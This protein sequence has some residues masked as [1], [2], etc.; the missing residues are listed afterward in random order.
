MKR[1][2]VEGE[3]TVLL[4]SWHRYGLRDSL[5]YREK[6]LAVYTRCREPRVSDSPNEQFRSKK[7]VRKRGERAGLVVCLLVERAALSKK[8]DRSLGE[9]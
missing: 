1:L 6:R 5:A 7:E 2:L 8:Y 9:G 3:R 4:D